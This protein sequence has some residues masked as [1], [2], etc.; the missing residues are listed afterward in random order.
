MRK[1][2]RHL[3]IRIFIAAFILTNC[4]FLGA[5]ITSADEELDLNPYS[6]DGDAELT[7]LKTGGST[8]IEGM[9]T[10]VAENSTL[11]LYMSSTQTSIAVLD[12]RTGR[13][14]YSNPSNMA[15][16][17]VAAGANK[18]RLKS[19]LYLT[20]YDRNGQK[21][22]YDN[23]FDCIR[24]SQFD[25][26]KIDNGVRI[27]Y[28]IGNM[29]K[30]KEDIPQR[31]NDERYNEIFMQNP[32]L[33]DAD[34]TE[35]SKRYTYLEGMEVWM[36]SSTGGDAAVQSTLKILT[37]AGYTDADLIKDNK[38]EGIPSYISDKVFY[39]IPVEYRIDGENFIASIPMDEIKYPESYPVTQIEFMEFFGASF[40]SETNGYTFIPDGSGALIKF[41]PNYK[42]SDQYY[43]TVYGDDK[44]I[45][46][47]EKRL[48]AEQ[49]AMP[50]YGQKAGN[51]AFLAIIEDGETMANIT[52]YRA[53][54]LNA[55]YSVYPT[56]TTIAMDYVRLGDGNS[57]SQ[58][59]TFQPDLYEGAFKIRYAFLEGGEAD[60]S[61]MARY[62][63][64]Y[65]VSRYNMKKADT[66]ENIPFYLET[67]GAIKKTK[68]VLGITYTGSVALTKYEDVKEIVEELKA[69]NINNIKLMFSGWFNDG[70]NESGASGIKIEG[71]LGGTGAFR[72]LVAYTKSEGIEFYPSVSFLKFS[73][74]KRGFSNY[75]DAARNL[76]DRFARS[77]LYNLVTFGRTVQE[78]VLSPRRLPKVVDKFLDAYDKYD[79][80]GV[81]LEDMGTYVN[82]DFNTR[83]LVLR[84]DA[85][86]VQQAEILKIKEATGRILINDGNAY[87]APYADYI[88]SAPLSNSGFNIED[89]SVPFYQM[90]YHAYVQYAGDPI[91]LNESQRNEILKIM[92]YGAGIYFKWIYQE[93]SIMKQTSYDQIYSTNYSDWMGEAASYYVAANGALKDVQD[94]LMIKHEKLAVKVYKT[95]YENGTEIIVNYSSEPVTFNGS[96]IAALD[97]LVL[98]GDK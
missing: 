53:G 73:N 9:D 75:R 2:Y 56:I 7:P 71:I 66:D 84:Q 51:K 13:I 16:D 36:F 82:S 26:F 96:T 21:K 90:V 49:V 95:T 35:I 80:S 72:E 18:D 83:R 78:F 97:Y 20:Y 5:G 81:A 14:W 45:L 93:S 44:G 91:N 64:N 15:E 24:R 92:E 17:K 52:A 98:K 30:G 65:L 34:K 37:K 54:R 68:S 11:A 87:A 55:F 38:A 86:E 59:P 6:A 48:Q 22:T 79:I 58:I 12:K 27:T 61:G 74:T 29:V 4:L 60:Y 57:T 50:V 67:L 19:Q 28:K 89:E 31:L 70:M 40:I 62:Y 63:R 77:F 3:F 47:F 85:L 76:D 33:S 41:D 39:V 23:Y 8:E 46:V 88:L 25:I 69:N 1:K 10:L 43:S 42:M 94:Q 32:K